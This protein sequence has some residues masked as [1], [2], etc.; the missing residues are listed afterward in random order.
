VSEPKA[1]ARE[2]REVV[3]G[4]WHW[5]LD[6]ERI[7]GFI[8]AS[9]AV[10]TE[11]G[12]VLV[13]PHPLAEDALAGLGAMAAIVLTASV[14]Q[15]AAWRLRRELAVPVWVPAATREAEEEPNERYSEGD[16]LPGGLKAIFTPGAGTT[17]HTLIDRQ[18]R[19]AFV[20]DLLVRPRGGRLALLS[21]DF[22]HDPAQLRETVETRLLTLDIDILCLGHG[23]PV[24]DDPTGAL[25]A[26]LGT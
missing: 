25:R 3:P 11:E 18:R 5:N 1:L 4:L 6:D 9:H 10:A 8:G 19:A 2:A 23:M 14:H 26:A 20:S 22:A 12:T 21:E 13:D 24:I 15:R 17:Q 7:G 16:R